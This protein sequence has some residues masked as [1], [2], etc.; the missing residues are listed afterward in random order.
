LEIPLGLSVIGIHPSIQRDIGSQSI[1]YFGVKGIRD[2]RRMFQTSLF[3][4]QVLRGNVDG[5]PS[6]YQSDPSNLDPEDI[7]TCSEYLVGYQ[8][9]GSHTLV[10]EKKNM[11]DLVI[12]MEDMYGNKEGVFSA[13]RKLINRASVDRT[14]SKQ[15]SMCF[16]EQLPLIL[17]LERIE[18]LS[19]SPSKCIYN[20]KEAKKDKIVEDTS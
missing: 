14:I 5:N 16:L 15:E 13:T 10:L 18:P 3:L 17:C 6:L 20:Q 12:N 7:L 4:I 11:K 1:L 8:M 19:L 2:T 9:K